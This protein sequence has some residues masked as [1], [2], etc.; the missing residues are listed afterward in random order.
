MLRSN[1]AG[2]RVTVD[3][4]VRGVTPLNISGLAYGS[5]TIRVERPGYET[6]RG[7][8]S[9]SSSRPTAAMTIALENA[10]ARAAG[11]SR[12]FRG[13]LS[14]ISRPSGASVYLDGR[15]IGTTP[16]VV[17]DVGAGSH[18]VRL[19]MPGYRRWSSAVLVVAD[20]RTR[21]TASLDRGGHEH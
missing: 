11:E 8:V 20:E 6:V 18:A 1:P 19:E 3:G 14:V 5:H 13:S 2:A 16:L 4:R 12:T 7:R 21:V 15:L 17:G 9:I 10:P